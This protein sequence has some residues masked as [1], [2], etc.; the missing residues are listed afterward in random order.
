MNDSIKSS[1]QKLKKTIDD[2]KRKL[3]AIRTGRASPALVENIAV[4][5]YGTSVPIKQLAG[6]SVPESRS[7]RI[8]PYDKNALKDI[9]KAILKSDL[10]ITPKNEGGVIHLNLP[11]L[12]EERRKELTKVI[13]HLGEEHKV[14]LRNIRREVMDAL[15]KQKG[16]GELSEDAEKKKEQELQKL[17]DKYVKDIDS[18]I[19]SKHKEIM[20]V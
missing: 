6:I 10:G 12:T 2:C 16:S 13:K 11:Q 9:E 4:E 14:S 20:E 3:A 17:I 18:I 7:I 15:K 19:D 5:Y 1:E 8:Q